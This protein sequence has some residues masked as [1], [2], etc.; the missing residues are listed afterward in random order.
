MLSGCFLILLGVGM[1]NFFGPE[2]K[3]DK[4]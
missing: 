2:L 1:T 4:L 3:E